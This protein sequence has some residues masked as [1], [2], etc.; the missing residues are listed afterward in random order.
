M[1]MAVTSKLVVAARI[2]LAM[3]AFGMLL[4]PSSLRHNRQAITAEVVQLLRA[5]PETT[6]EAEI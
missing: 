4:Y 5:Q 3:L 2:T 6:L 1:L